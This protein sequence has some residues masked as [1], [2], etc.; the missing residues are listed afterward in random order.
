M[1]F[2][3]ILITNWPATLIAVTPLLETE[4]EIIILAPFPPISRETGLVKYTQRQKTDGKVRRLGQPMPGLFS[5]PIDAPQGEAGDW[6]NAMP[7]TLAKTLLE[8]VCRKSG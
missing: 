7:F 8:R 2:L 3:P 4:R 6:F 5:G 1:A